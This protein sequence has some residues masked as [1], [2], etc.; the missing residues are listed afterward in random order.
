M[1][2]RFLPNINNIY[3]DNKST[4]AMA[5]YKLGESFNTTVRK[6]T[7]IAGTNKDTK[8]MKSSLS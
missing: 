4:P 8:I 7:M 5:T 2:I 3:G 1:S 6:T